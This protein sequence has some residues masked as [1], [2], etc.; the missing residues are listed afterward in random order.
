MFVGNTDKLASDPNTSAGDP[1]M[2]AGNPNI[3]AGDPKVFI[4]D[5]TVRY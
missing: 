4:C 5:I 1:D 3:S 2:F